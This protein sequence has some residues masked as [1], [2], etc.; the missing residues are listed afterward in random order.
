MTNKSELPEGW[1]MPPDMAKRLSEGLNKKSVTPENT[2]Q[3]ALDEIARD[4]AL[5]EPNP[6]DWGWWVSYLLEQLDAEARKGGREQGFTLML[7]EI[8]DF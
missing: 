1:A 4:I 6:Q 8:V 7:R 5:I 3:K 2:Q